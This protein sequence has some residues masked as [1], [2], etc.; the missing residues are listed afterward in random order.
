MPFLI[1]VF[2]IVVVV[3]GGSLFKSAAVNARELGILAPS[4]ERPARVSAGELFIIEVAI[5][6]ALTPP[7]GVQK[8]SVWRDW[9][10]YVSRD[11]DVAFGKASKRMQYE[12]RLL[13]IRPDSQNVNYIFTAE[14]LHWLPPGKYSIAI[15]GPGLQYRARDALVA[16]PTAQARQRLFAG[17]IAALG[18]NTWQLVQGNKNRGGWLELIAGKDAPAVLILLN[19]KRVRD[20][21]VYW[22]EYAMRR[23]NDNS[24]LLRIWI[25]A[26]STATK[27]EVEQRAVSKQRVSIESK[28]SY[29]RPMAWVTLRAKTSFFPVNIF[30][31][32]VDGDNRV[33][34]EVTYR[35]MVGTTAKAT[36]TAFDE[37]STPW[38]AE[39]NQPLTLPLSRNADCSFGL[40]AGGAPVLLPQLFQFCI[41]S[42]FNLME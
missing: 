14:A 37:F 26:S 24:R 34:Q 6:M 12:L 8:A 39:L 17:A 3:A 11:A 15:K 22:G 4:A 32:F 38:S 30:W 36:V 27:L 13:R 20:L 35:W 25:P 33:G 1:R 40:G 21:Q 19:G 23:P 31:D 7:P 18:A 42:F 29:L 9:H 16:T 28:S 41:E 2:L 5:P 10:L